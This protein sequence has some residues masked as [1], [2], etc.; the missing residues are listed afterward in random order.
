MLRGDSSGRSFYLRVREDIAV[1]HMAAV[2][3]RHPEAAAGLGLGGSRSATNHPSSSSSGSQQQQQPISGRM[4][5]WVTDPDLDAGIVSLGRLKSLLKRPPTLAKRTGIPEAQL[6]RIGEWLA[7]ADTGDVTPE[8]DADGSLSRDNNEHDGLPTSEHTAEATA[9]GGNNGAGSAVQAPFGLPNHVGLRANTLPHPLLMARNVS[10]PRAPLEN[11]TGGGEEHQN[12]GSSSPSSSSRALRATGS[13]SATAAAVYQD[14]RFTITCPCT[15]SVVVTLGLEA[16]LREGNSLD[17]SR[18]ADARSALG[19]LLNQKARRLAEVEAR[20]C[21]DEAGRARVEERLAEL[22]LRSV[23][24]QRAGLRAARL[25]ARAI[26]AR[27]V[28][29]ARV[30]P[31]IKRAAADADSHNS[32]GG[33]TL[34]HGYDGEAS[35]LPEVDLSGRV[36]LAGASST[37]ALSSPPL[38]AMAAP[39]HVPARATSRSSYLG[40]G[41]HGASMRPGT[42]IPGNGVFAEKKAT[43]TT[44]RSSEGSA[45]GKRVS[46]ADLSLLLQSVPSSRSSAGHHHPLAEGNQHL[47]SSSSDPTNGTVDHGSSSLRRPSSEARLTFGDLLEVVRTAEG[48]RPSPDAASSPPSSSSTKPRTGSEPTALPPTN[49]P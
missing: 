44:V 12:A 2:T 24:V 9:L 48:P 22:L 34:R 30:L 11:N 39:H 47:G 19:T 40:G 31:L 23:R 49:L 36:Y 37:T 45:H 25:E 28:V 26:E 35:L 7:R 5:F 8:N 18:I 20:R 15:I 43:N 13:V 16:D 46:L 33:E 1:A 29:A 27:L 42:S 41:A 32:N 21:V 3:G 10:G 4:Y 17:G 38:R 6:E 14:R